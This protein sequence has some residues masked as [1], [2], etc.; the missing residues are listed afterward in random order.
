MS[1]QLTD[2][3]AKLL[4]DQSNRRARL[5]KTV[6]GTFLR[7]LSSHLLSGYLGVLGAWMLILI[8]ERAIWKVEEDF[9]SSILS[10]A[11]VS[12]AISAVYVV[13]LNK[14]MN[15]LIALLRED[16]LLQNAPPVAKLIDKQ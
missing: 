13:I 11:L 4:L 9:T 3:E 2:A 6:Q 15:A 12:I 8:L 7:Y 1:N 14:R 5:L 16:G 10:L